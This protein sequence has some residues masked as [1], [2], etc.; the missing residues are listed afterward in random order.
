MVILFWKF[1]LP[2]WLIEPTRLFHFGNFSNLHVI[3]NCT[4][5]REVRVVYFRAVGM[6][7]NLGV[8]VFFVWYTY[9]SLNFF[10]KTCKKLRVES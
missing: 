4:L 10:L 5:I 6:S 1:F 8:L 2:T 3:S 7:E 9:G